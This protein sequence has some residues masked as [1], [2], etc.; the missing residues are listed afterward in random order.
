MIYL[1]QNF[2]EQKREELYQTVEQKVQAIIEIK[3]FIQ[4]KQ[5]L[6]YAEFCQAVEYF[7]KSITDRFGEE[8]NQQVIRLEE[9][10]KE[11]Q[12]L[13]E[14]LI[15]FFAK[16][17]E[18]EVIYLKE[19]QELY[20]K[21]EEIGQELEILS[22][23]DN[24]VFIKKIN[25]FFSSTTLKKRQVKEASELYEKDKEEFIAHLRKKLS[26]ELS[27]D[28]IVNIEFSGLNINIILK[29]EDFEKLVGSETT[30]GVHYLGT[31]IN[32]LK[33]NNFEEAKKHEENHNL[34]DSF[35]EHSFD[36][37]NLLNYLKISIDR[38]HTQKKI[39]TPQV[40]IDNEL[41]II[42]KLLT[43]YHHNN[44]N[45]LIADLD[46]LTDG[47]IY[48]FYS[49]FSS[50]LTRLFKFVKT[51]NDDEI[52]KLILD[53]IEVMINNFSKL[54]REFATIFFAAKRIGKIE[55]AKAAIILFEH[56]NLAKVFRHLRSYKNFEFYERI[57]PLIH[58]GSFYKQLTKKT[59]RYKI[60]DFL[61]EKIGL[62][63][64]L[65]LLLA[66]EDC[67]SPV[68]FFN[69][70]NLKRL[71]EILKN[72][73][74]EL[75]IEEEQALK[76]NI[77]NFL[78]NIE[79]ICDFFTIKNF[80]FKQIIEID[81][82]LKEIGRVLKVDSFETFVERNIAFTY[83][84][85]CFIGAI[86]QGD[87]S[88]LILISQNWPFDPK[89]ITRGISELLTKDL[90]KDYYRKK[91]GKKF[92]LQGLKQTDLWELLKKLELEK[93]V[94]DIMNEQ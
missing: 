54:M 73:H 53:N 56:D 46:I 43:E 80:T 30:F 8:T 27:S 62:R 63:K 71:C 88:S 12:A 91:T 58:Q 92:N 47:N 28:A 13:N 89:I 81:G 86:E 70:P 64:D 26:I 79:L 49:N 84:Q 17:D 65:R 14:K 51:S 6:P 21:S 44:F 78:D 23:D 41:N 25:D 7:K 40:F 87:L 4:E 85:S 9:L 60:E 2:R 36:K 38:Y 20:D 55:E 61:F 75:T 39:K 90:L 72:D 16:G 10:I 48:T 11:N 52:K 19:Y 76:N 67:D 50:A 22:N 94:L 59:E 74:C 18:I 3:Q 93:N 34:S 45:E 5:G 15:E 77:D 66:I 32:I 82:Y 57:F 35:T 1:E 83:I 42:K 68:Y 37:E 69:L 33:E 24:L 31:V 29:N